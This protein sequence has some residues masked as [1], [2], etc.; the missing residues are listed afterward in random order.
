MC[1]EI[2][3][4]L[5]W[6]ACP[7]CGKD[8]SKLKESGKCWDCEEKAEVEARRMAAIRAKLLRMFG[9]DKGLIRLS[10]QN[11]LEVPGTSEAHSYALGFDP[12]KDNVY[13]FGATG[14]GKTHL[15]YALA[16][17]LA[18][19]GKSVEI[20]TVRQLVKR[21][22]LAKPEEETERADTL[23]NVD[24]LVVDDLGKVANS[25]FALDILTDIIGRRG[26]A[27]KNGLIVTSNLGL[28]QLAAKNLD[29]RLSSRLA[30]M[31]R[32]IRIQT[33]K[34]FRLERRT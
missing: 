9:S 28:D 30:G 18:E 16:Q 4:R 12:S 1:A 27:E 17:K 6:V 13:F 3:A 15:A 8:W 31:C 26:L 14:R 33:E 29:D 5:T 24:V 2:G 22:R 21:F 23:A 20:M 32:V 25:E 19:L 34:D 10:F 7:I 11:W